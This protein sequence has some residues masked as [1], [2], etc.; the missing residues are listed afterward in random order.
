MKRIARDGDE[1]QLLTAER[2]AY[3]WRPGQRAAVKRLAAKRDRQ[4]SRQALRSGQEG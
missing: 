1:Q 2:K 3:R 4:E